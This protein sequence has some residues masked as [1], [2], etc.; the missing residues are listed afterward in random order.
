MYRE[1]GE[2][3]RHTPSDIWFEK[4]CYFKFVLQNQNKKILENPIAK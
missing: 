1:G 4:F 3:N 2:G